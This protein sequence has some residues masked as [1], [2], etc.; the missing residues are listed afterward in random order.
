MPQLRESFLRASGFLRKIGLRSEAENDLLLQTILTRREGIQRHEEVLKVSAVA[1]FTL[2]E[3]QALQGHFLCQAIIEAKMVGANVHPTVGSEIVISDL[4]DQS[5]RAL[6][7]EHVKKGHVAALSDPANLQRSQQGIP[8]LQANADVASG[9]KVESNRITAAATL[10]SRPVEAISHAR[11]LKISGR[12]DRA[13][14]SGRRVSGPGE[15]TRRRNAQP[16]LHDQGDAGHRRSQLDLIRISIQLNV[17]AELA[18][19]LVVEFLI[20]Q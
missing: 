15:R 6:G 1:Q 9:L 11:N 7:C 5:V 13:A 19:P 12:V 8:L 10:K 3:E 16:V 18:A 20:D 14:G 2:N 4:R 17:A